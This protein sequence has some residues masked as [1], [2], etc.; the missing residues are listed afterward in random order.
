MNRVSYQRSAVTICAVALLAASACSQEAYVKKH[1]GDRLRGVVTDA[2]YDAIVLQNPDNGATAEVRRREIAEIHHPGQTGR[3]VGIF[4]IVVGSVVA[5]TGGGILLALATSPG[6]G[7]DPMGIVSFGGGSLA[8][9]GVTTVVGSTA[10]FLWSRH[11]YQRSTE[12]SIP[13]SEPGHGD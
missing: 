11:A 7:S 12:R 13:P 5:L 3:A 1:D 8:V 10:G 9:I 6:P 4:G 2:S